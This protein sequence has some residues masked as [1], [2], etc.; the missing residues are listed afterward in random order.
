MN[1]DDFAVELETFGLHLRGVLILA[2]E[3]VKLRIRTGNPIPSIVG[4]D[5]SPIRWRKYLGQGRF[6]H[7]KDRRI[8]RFCNG[9]NEPNPLASHRWG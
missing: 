9:R 6:I 3:E 2:T 5:V 8:T 1:L 7:S 4:A